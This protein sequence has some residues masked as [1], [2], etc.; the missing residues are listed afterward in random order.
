MYTA[1]FNPSFQPLF[2]V[3][4]KHG[5]NPPSGIPINA[6]KSAQCDL[7]NGANAKAAIIHFEGVKQA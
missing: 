2:H 4:Q 7:F 6:T 3:F 1:F 5:I